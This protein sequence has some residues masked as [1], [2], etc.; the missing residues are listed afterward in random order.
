M[1]LAHKTGIVP[2]G[3]VLLGKSAM[4]TIG[5]QS[6]TCIAQ[7]EGG[8]HSLTQRIESVMAYGVFDASIIGHNFAHLPSRKSSTCSLVECIPN[9]PVFGTLKTGWFRA[10]TRC[11]SSQG[12]ARMLP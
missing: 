12:F 6:S 11:Q 9:L 3:E 10:K 4:V 5:V 8:P 2:L 7:G 1:I